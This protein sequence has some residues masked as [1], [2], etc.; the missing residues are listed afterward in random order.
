M[1]P[2]EKY[3]EVNSLTYTNSGTLDTY[4]TKEEIEQYK[5]NYMHAI[6]LAYSEKKDVLVKD[7]QSDEYNTVGKYWIDIAKDY[8]TNNAYENEEEVYAGEGLGI[9]EEGPVK[10]ISNMCRGAAPYIRQFPSGETVLSYGENNKESENYLKTVLSLGNEEGEFSGGN[11]VALEYGTWNSMELLSS[12]C[13]A[14]VISNINSISSTKEIGINP[15]YL[16]HTINTKSILETGNDDSNTDALFIGS[17]SQAQ[18]TIRSAYDE[19]NVYFIIDRLDESLTDEDTVELYVNTE[20]LSDNNYKYYKIILSKDGIKECYLYDQNN[21]STSI[22]ID[23]MKCNAYINDTKDEN[24][25]YR[26]E[27]SI[28]KEDILEKNDSTIMINAILNNKD[29]DEALTTD[30]FNNVDMDDTSTW[31]KIKIKNVTV[32]YAIT[33]DGYTKITINSSEEMKP[34]DSGWTLSEDKLS[35]SKI[36]LKN[37]N[38]KITIYSE[39][40]EVQII[41]PVK[42]IILGDIN[43]DDLIDASDLLL[44]KRHLVHGSKELW[45]LTGDNFKAADLNRDGTVDE[46]DLLMQKRKVLKNMLGN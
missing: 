33:E 29:A 37:A 43:Q 35:Q 39:N 34:V 6:S 42:T 20:H 36:Y 15:M 26:L 44:I 7:A 27:L 13:I 1:S 11:L 30:T 28:P 32:E 2:R 4:W 17:E 45:I 12:H 24:G 19:E 5:T 14:A 18:M 41:I 21:N 3:N 10:R 40:G 23:K 9:L 31:N 46:S 25:G 22:N 16:N 8:G 38:E